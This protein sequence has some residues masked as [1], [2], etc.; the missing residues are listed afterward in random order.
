GGGNDQHRRR[1]GGLPIACPLGV[2]TGASR[3]AWASSARK[4]STGKERSLTTPSRTR[5]TTQTGT[6]P[7][8]KVKAKYG[9]NPWEAKCGASR[10]I[11]LPVTTVC[12]LQKLMAFWAYLCF[13]EHSAFYTSL[14]LLEM[15]I[16]I[17]FSK[18]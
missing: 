17:K 7:G 8:Q 10:H 9:G 5:W 12:D 1:P 11:L 2:G 18:I 4:R 14:V 15:K 3:T 16:C 6:R 13:T